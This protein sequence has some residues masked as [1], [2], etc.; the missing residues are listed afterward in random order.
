[1][2]QAILAF[3]HLVSAIDRLFQKRFRTVFPQVDDL[4]ADPLKELSASEITIGPMHRYAMSIVLGCGLGFCTCCGWSAYRMDHPRPNNGPAKLWELGS[5][6]GGMLLVTAASGFVIE[7]LV[8]GGQLVIRSNGV[9]FR[10]RSNSIFLP[11]HAIS[12]NG[13]F[14]LAENA[15]VFSPGAF[16]IASLVQ[17]RHGIVVATGAGVWTRPVEV[18][19]DGRVVLEDMYK[20]RLGDVAE[21][22]TEL[23]GKLRQ[24]SAA[25]PTEP[26]QPVPSEMA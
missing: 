8:R 15:A 26:G 10:H 18:R 12:T 22:L 9:V 1:V 17:S 16:A 13:S 2:G 3:A 24:L 21:L 7:R 19:K 11:W 6:L 20:V 14:T 4:I 23:C 5:V 25:R